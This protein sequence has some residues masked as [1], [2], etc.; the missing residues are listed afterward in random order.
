MDLA[1]KRHTGKSPDEQ[2]KQLPLLSSC[3]CARTA[4]TQRKSNPNNGSSC[5]RMEYQTPVECWKRI[6]MKEKKYDYMQKGF[7]R[8]SATFG[9]NPETVFALA[10][11][12]NH[13][14][15][16]EAVAQSQ[17]RQRE[18]WQWNLTD[19][20]TI[21]RRIFN[22]ALSS[23]MQDSVYGPLYK[24]LVR[25][26]I[27]QI[28]FTVLDWALR[29]HYGISLK[30]EIEEEEERKNPCATQET[31]LFWNAVTENTPLSQ[32]L[33]RLSG[34]WDGNVRRGA[35]ILRSHIQLH[36]LALA[37]NH[38]GSFLIQT[39]LAMSLERINWVEVAALI[40]GIPSVPQPPLEGE[41]REEPD[42]MVQLA[43]LQEVI[44]ILPLFSG[45]YQE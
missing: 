23:L 9:V 14:Q 34:N 19:P 11:F 15:R 31:A 18:R 27:D 43:R 36:R 22:E 10:L 8:M 7:T 6:G 37:Q 41:E 38:E 40:L 28:D 44:L 45:E 33:K 32:Q 3:L 13:P 21:I 1:A 2:K 26:H 17:E 39:V 24:R 12:S 4:F 25:F 42:H 5:R 20:E 30:Q 29:G 16:K 35:R